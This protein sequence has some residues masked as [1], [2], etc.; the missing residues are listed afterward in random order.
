MPNRRTHT[1]VGATAGIVAAAHAA[2]WTDEPGAII[3]TLGGGFGG[4]WGGR[5]P[6]M[7]DPPSHPNHRGLGHSGLAIAAL[8]AL[9]VSKW[10]DDLRGW[11]ADCQRRAAASQSDGERLLWVICA[12]LFRFLAGALEGIRA[13]YL[14]HLAMDFPTA[15]SLPILA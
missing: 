11:A 8:T 15:K 2:D 3:E 6:D 14:S 7:I 13:G 5:A 1:A 4:Y 9:P 12:A 10:K